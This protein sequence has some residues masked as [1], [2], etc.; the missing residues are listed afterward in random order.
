MKILLQFPEGLKKNALSEAQKLEKEGQEVYLSSSACYGACDLPMEEA[1]ALNIDKLIHFGH[2]QFIRTSL[3]FQV[4]YREYYAHLDVEKLEGA[5][6][7]LEGKERIVLVTTVQHIPQLEQVKSFLEKEGKEV[8]IGKGCFTA[9]PGQ[10]L[11][12]DPTAATSVSENADAILYVGDGKFHP[13]GIHSDL[14]VFSLNPSSGQC[15]QVN[16]EIEKIRKRKKGRMLKAL[17][18]KVFAVL[19][20]TKP[21]QFCPEVA[22]EAKRKLQDAGFAAEIL[23]SNEFNPVSIGNFPQFE[24]YINTACPRVDEDSELFDKPII[25]AVDLD[26]FLE[27][28]NESG[29]G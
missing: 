9:H 21:G 26:E 5:L 22:R 18:C 12:C 27:L 19:L 11:G 24:C 28:Y 17:E 10:V 13:T 14:P 3:P 23:V 6:S 7:F 20:S 1:S 25:N 29:S 16:D 2:S 4:E 8:L 15:R